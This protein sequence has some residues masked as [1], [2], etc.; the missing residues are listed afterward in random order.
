[1]ASTLHP[2]APDIATYVVGGVQEHYKA[3]I[4]RN[5]RWVH[6]GRSVAY[7]YWVSDKI[8]A[9]DNGLITL[10]QGINV[11]LPRTYR[12]PSIKLRVNDQTL[13]KQRFPSDSTQ[14]DWVF[15]KV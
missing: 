3:D 10:L 9:L 8:V 12:N 15:D 14:L 1:M 2:N 4:Y 11:T 7:R 5:L 6:A 13:S